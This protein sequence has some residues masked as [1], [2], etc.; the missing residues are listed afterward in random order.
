MLVIVTALAA[1]AST[2]DG[3]GTPGPAIA[4]KLES[5]LETP[6]D[7]DPATLPWWQQMTPIG[8]EVWRIAAL[9]T[10]SFLAIGLAWAARRR[11]PADPP[12]RPEQA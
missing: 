11:R 3:Q 1:V 4:Q 6:A 12:E 7:T 9:F 10:A 2:A 5:V 8:N